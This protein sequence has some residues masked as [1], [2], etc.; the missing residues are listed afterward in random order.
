MRVAQAA[1]GISDISIGNASGKIVPTIYSQRIS[2]TNPNVVEL[3]FGEEK[4]PDTPMLGYGIG[5]G[6]DMYVNLSDDAG[7]AAVDQAIAEFQ[8]RYAADHSKA[9]VTV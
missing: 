6:R 9:T 3:L 2:E 5:F 7:M 4:L 8:K 1:S